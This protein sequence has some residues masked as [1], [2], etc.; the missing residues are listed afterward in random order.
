MTRLDTFRGM[1]TAAGYRPRVHDDYI[2]FQHEGGNYL[3][4]LDDA[5]PQFFRIVFPNFWHFDTEAERTRVLETAATVT[6]MVKAVKIFP[7][8]N[9]TIASI[10][11]LLPNADAFDQ[12]FPRAL[13]MLQSACREFAGAMHMR[14]AGSS[15][16]DQI[17]RLFE[18]GGEAGP[19]AEAG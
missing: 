10:D 1:L 17:R 13:L 4:P 3:L 16:M 5:D 7:G 19:Q 14:S 2:T 6:G 9:D 12:V 15:V 18:G 11:L 8:P